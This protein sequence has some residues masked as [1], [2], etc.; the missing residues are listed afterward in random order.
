MPKL[1]Y[2]SWSVLPFSRM[3]GRCVNALVSSSKI[4]LNP[5]VFSVRHHAAMPS[6]PCEFLGIQRQPSHKHLCCSEA[7]E[8]RNP[9]KTPATECKQVCCC[10]L[11]HQHCGCSPFRPRRLVGSGPIIASIS[12]RGMRCVLVTLLHFVG[13]AV[14]YDSANHEDGRRGTVHTHCLRVS[15]TYVLLP[16]L[17]LHFVPRHRAACIPLLMA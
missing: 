11:N 3:V 15:I 5:S 13:Q 6:S 2:S 4:V 1:V 17:L 16:M 8:T 9:D 7:N 10:L 14:F 12:T